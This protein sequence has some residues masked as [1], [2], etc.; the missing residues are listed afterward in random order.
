MQDVFH[1]TMKEAR[2]SYFSTMGSAKSLHEAFLNNNALHKLASSFLSTDS[3][4][5]T[6]TIIRIAAC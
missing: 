2:S 3:A 5:D 1:K 6:N 4:H